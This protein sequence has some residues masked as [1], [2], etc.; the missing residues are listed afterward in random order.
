[1]IFPP[2]CMYLIIIIIVVVCI[3][4]TYVKCFLEQHRFY[5]LLKLLRNHT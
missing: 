3:F 4:V 2:S 5:I 1:M